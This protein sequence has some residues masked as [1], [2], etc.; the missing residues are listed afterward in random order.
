M[1]GGLSNQRSLYQS[2]HVALQ[3]TPSGREECGPDHHHGAPHSH[4]LVSTAST[5]SPSLRRELDCD[6]CGWPLACGLFRE[7]VLYNIAKRTGSCLGQRRSW[8]VRLDSSAF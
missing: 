3:A 2:S 1:A 8:P 5:H 7:R 4:V 6:N